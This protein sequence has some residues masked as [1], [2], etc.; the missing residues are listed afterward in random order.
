MQAI[1]LRHL[2]I[3]SL[4]LRTG[5]WSSWSHCGIVMPDATVIQACA[6]DGVI[7]TPLATVL[8]NASDSAMKVIDLPNDDAAYTFAIEQLGKPYDWPGA[9]GLALH[10]EWEIDDA[11]FCSELIE[12]AAVAGGRRRFVN[13][14]TRITPQLSWMVG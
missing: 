5:M 12:A 1:Y 3:G 14:P 2:N 6:L 8:A 10:R 13:N 11:W 9:I 7:R 4:L